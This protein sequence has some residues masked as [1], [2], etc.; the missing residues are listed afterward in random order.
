[1]RIPLW[2]V[3]SGELDQAL[4]LRLAYVN[5]PSAWKNSTLR[6][7]IQD[8]LQYPRKYIENPRTTSTSMI[9]ILQIVLATLLLAFPCARKLTAHETKCISLSKL[10]PLA[11]HRD[12]RINNTSAFVPVFVVS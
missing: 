9:L 3:T 12:G 2:F 11:H 6:E 1:M 4:I 5:F 7:K 8:H 10:A